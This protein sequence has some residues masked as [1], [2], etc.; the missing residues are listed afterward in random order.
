MGAE[1][2]VLRKNRKSSEQGVNNVPEGASQRYLKLKIFRQV[3]C[4]DYQTHS[5][6]LRKAMRVLYTSGQTST[7]A[8]DH[9]S[10]F[11]YNQVD[12]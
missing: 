9:Q 4:S 7:P 3:S 11:F 5:S 2:P 1:A 6:F 8:P 10:D 12:Q